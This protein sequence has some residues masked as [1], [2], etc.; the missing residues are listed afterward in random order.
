MGRD[1]H[2]QLQGFMQ[3]SGVAKN[4]HVGLA[5]LRVMG[6]VFEWAASPRYCL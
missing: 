1:L 2:Q 6:V 4:K 5:L 3:S